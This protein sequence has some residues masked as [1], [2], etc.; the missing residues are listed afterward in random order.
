MG[1]RPNA[2]PA[3]WLLLAGLLTL[4]VLA[5]SWFAAAHRHRGAQRRIGERAGIL[6]A[7]RPIP[8]GAFVAT[9]TMPGPLRA[10]S[11]HQPVTPIIETARGLLTGTEIGNSGPIA[12]AWAVSLLAVSITLATTLYRHRITQ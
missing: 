2:T 6:H 8:V 9:D 1:F 11:D 7:L 5:L 4:Y 3:E 10:I 12:L